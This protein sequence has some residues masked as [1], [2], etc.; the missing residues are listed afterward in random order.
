[1]VGDRSLSIG[2][3]CLLRG[4]G[5]GAWSDR[6]GMGWPLRAMRWAVV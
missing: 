2:G 1:M 4:E 3:I 5:G 6:R